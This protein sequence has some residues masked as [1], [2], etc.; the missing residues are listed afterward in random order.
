MYAFECT[1]VYT[2]L[3]ISAFESSKIRI[4]THSKKSRQYWK[5]FLFYYGTKLTCGAL[6]LKT[7]QK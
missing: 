5:I 4:F 2:C 3:H 7:R 1:N 6:Y